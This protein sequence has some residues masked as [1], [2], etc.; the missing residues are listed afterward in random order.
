MRKNNT[1]ITRVPALIALATGNKAA[2]H[3]ATVLEAHHPA[4]VKRMK[5]MWP[6]RDVA[7]GIHQLVQK[8][9]IWEYTFVDASLVFENSEFVV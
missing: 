3:L 1:Q 9:A 5:L 7:A 8:V 4:C 6:R 2:S